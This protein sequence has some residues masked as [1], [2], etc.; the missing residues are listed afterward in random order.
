M[1]AP[2]VITKITQ[3]AASQLCGVAPVTQKSSVDA[4]MLA[5]VALREPEAV[6]QRSLE[7]NTKNIYISSD[8]CRNPS[9]GKGHL[10]GHGIL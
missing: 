6:P 4:G 9:E 5:V 7:A 1:Y 10:K 2:R 8:P 3:N